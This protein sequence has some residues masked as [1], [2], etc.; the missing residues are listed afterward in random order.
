MQVPGNTGYS[1]FDNF[2]FKKTP[3]PKSLVKEQE[4]AEAATKEKQ[5][6][7]T[8]VR[9][10][11]IHIRVSFPK[12]LVKEQE[13]AEG[14]PRKRSRPCPGPNAALQ[15]NYTHFTLGSWYKFNTYSFKRVRTLL[16]NG[17]RR[18]RKRSRFVEFN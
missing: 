4:R 9:V 13:R 7:P 1:Y 12:A 3:F 6:C 8:H 11:L 17:R 18:R 14:L 2:K 16:R 5:V 15:A 10:C